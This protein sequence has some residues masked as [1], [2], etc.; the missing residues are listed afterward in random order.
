MRNY[1]YQILFF[2]VFCYSYYIQ[3]LRNM[4]FS[5]V[6]FLASLI[7]EKKRSLINERK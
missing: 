7:L 1:I 5:G 3:D 2:A 6:L 4:I